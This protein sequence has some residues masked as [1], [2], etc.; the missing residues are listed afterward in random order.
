MNKNYD[1]YL[2]RAVPHEWSVVHTDSYGR[3]YVWVGKDKYYV[4]KP[5]TSGDVEIHD[6]T[7]VKQFE[8]VDP[9]I[10]LASKFVLK[11]GLA[12]FVLIGICTYLSTK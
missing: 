12:L 9:N 3:R 7:P 5:H 1:K 2:C 11:I 4:S 6:L 8:Q 10:I